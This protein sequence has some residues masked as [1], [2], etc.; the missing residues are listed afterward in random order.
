MAK[1]KSLKKLLLGALL[2]T[3]PLTGCSSFFGEEGTIISNITTTYNDSEGYTLVT[4]TFAD[5][6]VAP[7]TFKVYDGD[8][9]NG[10][11]DITAQ[12]N[13][14]TVTLT[15]I[16]TDEDKDPLVV[17]VPIIHGRGV[18]GIEVSTDNNGDTVL[19]FVYNDGTKSESIT[20]HNGVDG[21]GI[22]HIEAGYDANLNI[23]LTIYYTDPNKEPQVFTI[24]RPV[25]I[26]GIEFDAENSNK[27]TYA[28]IIHYSDGTTST[29]TMPAPKDGV[30]GEDGKD[31]E[32]GAPG[33]VWHCSTLLPT[34]KDGVVGDYWIHLITGEVYRKTT[35]TTW[36]RIFKFR[37]DN[38]NGD[39]EIEAYAD[40]MF[41]PGE[42]TTFTDTKGWRSVQVGKTLPLSQF[43]D[44][45]T[46]DGYTFLGWYTHIDNVN[47]GQF[48]DLTV[49]T[50]D[51]TLYARWSENTPSHIN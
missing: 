44:N 28:F 21:N 32:E 39:G 26:V 48:T 29:F 12:P 25:S 40:V 50:Q 33:S 10:I 34:A 27:T 9:G 16:Y 8:E 45:P 30:D 11:K 20:I 4:I 7:I 5:E 47:A 38:G 42:G 51:I 22:D 37:L 19:V 17:D 1:F 14:D 24:P 35:K 13:G 31:G 36:E 18:E 15:I 43:P 2:L 3:T 46:K 23:V 6:E 41:V 49:V